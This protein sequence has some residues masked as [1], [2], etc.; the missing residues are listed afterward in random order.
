MKCILLS[1]RN[2]ISISW[3]FIIALSISAVSCSGKKDAV[4]KEESPNRPA[5]QELEEDEKSDTIWKKDQTFKIYDPAVIRM[6][7]TFLFEGESYSL[8]FESTPLDEKYEGIRVYK[9]SGKVIAQRCIGEN[10]IFK[11]KLIQG[12]DRIIKEKSFDKFDLEKYVGIDVLAGSDGTRWYFNDFNPAFGQFSFIS[13]WMFEDSDVGDEYMIFMDL[14]LNFNHFFLDSYTGG[15]SCDCGSSPSEDLRTYV[16]CDRILR[17]DGSHTKIGDK[18]QDLVATRILNNQY[19]LAV[20]THEGKPPYNNAKILRGNGSVAK[21]F[22]FEGYEL[23][24]GYMIDE[25][26]VSD[27]NALFLVDMQQESLFRIDKENPENVKR[28]RFDSMD[29]P[30]EKQRSSGRQFNIYTFE[31]RY[32]LTYFEQQFFLDSED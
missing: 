1:M 12:A 27:Q 29:A 6:D 7:T 8:H 22:D 18:N 11:F 32:T 24:L 13:R 16:F 19:I 21:S 31:N 4:E 14:N 2:I 9:D 3:I 17:S 10:R 25:L 20:Y 28:I 23:E 26:D 15:G 30:T 5:T